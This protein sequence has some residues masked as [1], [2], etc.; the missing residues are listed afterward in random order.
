[1][2]KFT[3]KLFACASAVLAFFAASP[4]QAQ[5]ASATDLY[6]TYEFTAT[7][8]ITADGK[9]YEDLFSDKCDVKIE[10]HSI[11]DFNIVGLGGSTNTE[12]QT[13][14]YSNGNI[15]VMNSNGSSYYYWGEPV[16]LGSVDGASPFDGSGWELNY[17]VDVNTKEITLQ[18]FTAIT[19]DGTWNTDKILA[20]F[21]NC[22]LTFKAAEV[23]E[24]ND[25]SGDY[26][27]TAGTGQ[28][29]VNSESSF[30]TEFDMNITATS[31]NF[32]AYKVT[33]N[34]GEG[35]VPVEMDATYDGINLTITV[36]ESYL[37]E[38]KT[39]AFADYYNPA[40]L[41]TTIV[42]KYVSD[43]ALSLTSGIVISK[44]VENEGVTTFEMEQY[45]MS[46]GAKKPSEEATF[47]GT[48]VVTCEGVYN[49]FE[50]AEGNSSDKYNVEYPN[51]FEFEIVQNESNG[52]YYVGTFMN[53]D[54]YANTWGDYPCE[55]DGNTLK[56]PVGD[57]VYINRVFANDEN[58]EIV[59]DVLYDGLGENTGTVDLTLNEDGTVLMT[60]FFIKR[61]TT[62]YDANW[63][64]TSTIES[65]AYYGYLQ[66]ERKQE[67]VVEPY[68]FTGTYWMSADVETY[69]SDFT[70]PRVDFK[71]KIEEVFDVDGNSAGFFVKD[72][73]HGNIYTST[74]GAY[75]CVIEGNVL[76]IA[77]GDDVK[78]KA[79]SFS[80]DWLTTNYDILY[81][82]AGENTGYITLTANEDGTFT[83]DNF[84]FNRL[85]QTWDAGYTN[86]TV[87]IGN[88]SASYSN[89][90][91]QK[92]GDAI[93]DVETVKPAVKVYAENGTIYVAGEAAAVSVYNLSG[94]RVFNGVAS[95][96]SGLANG[97]YI[98]KCGDTVVKVSL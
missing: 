27:F 1:M 67:E 8:E 59:Y 25:I 4:A 40:S 48:Y 61:K 54:I 6:G 21:T 9:E 35:Y 43:K 17:S 2:K 83:M 96:V 46:G 74:Y 75:P 92:E 53:G 56:L 33:V 64:A 3:S 94:V 10:A 82:G 68:D 85:T 93:E 18:D 45:Y 62:T 95:Q 7:M 15:R 86:K 79:V 29:D 57:A 13:A 31:V 49:F 5:V 72:F 91:V 20:K 37:N 88:K 51:T 22:K 76:K 89:I 81:N 39:Y 47:A 90:K 42:F 60:D 36:N 84:C 41:S 70:Y 44:A 66:V 87:T 58:T 26:H 80:D 12:G 32:D 19:V 52:N 38:E 71:M 77:V 50:D 34:Y 14:N 97:L 78:V 28:W 73:V 30:P 55:V 11:Y 65:A 69:V 24:L 98:V 23:I 16:V 63:A